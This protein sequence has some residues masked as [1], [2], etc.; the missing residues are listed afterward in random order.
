[1][2]QVY[3]VNTISCGLK[4]KTCKTD[5]GRDD[6]DLSQGNSLREKIENSTQ[7]I[8]KLKLV[9]SVKG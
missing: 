4:N 7:N 8:L 5:Q 1:M 6:E 2:G 9:R 3:I